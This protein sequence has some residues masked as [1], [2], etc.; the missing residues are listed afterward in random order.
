MELETLEIFIE[1]NTEKIQAQ[2]EPLMPYFD[3]VFGNIERI[4]GQSV[5]RTEKKM[6]VG[7]G[8]NN[9][10][11]QFE[12]MQ[13]MYEK[14]LEMME[15]ITSSSTANIEK[16]LTKG[17]Q[18]SRKTVGKEVDALVKDINN[19]MG[20]AKAE[21]EKLA[22]LQ[23]QR[24]DASS[25]GDTKNVV[26]YDG[27][28]ARAQEM[29]DKYQGS[30][31][32]MANTIKKEFK[33]LPGLMDSMSDEMQK[34]ESVIESQKA[35]V[36]ELT[37]LYETQ[38]KKVSKLSQG[39]L[40]NLYQKYG[41]TFDPNYQKEVKQA[42]F[43]FEDTK[44]SKKTNAEITKYNKEIQ[45]LI[46][47]NDALQQSYSQAEDRTKQLRSAVKGLN[48][49]L[50]KSSMVTGNAAMGMKKVGKGADDSKGLFSKFGGVFNRTS[51]NIAHGSRRMTTGISGFGHRLSQM[52]KQAFI[53][54][55][56]YK[57]LNM[58]TKGLGSALMA[59]DE[60]SS[61]L[62]QIKV[63]LLTAFY[64]IYTF[65][66]PAINSL[67]RA[68]TVATGQIAH[69]TASLFGTTYTA[70]KQGAQGLYQNIQAMNDSGNSADKNREKV[71]KL[72]RS[73]MGFDE[74]N[75]I[76]LDDKDDDKLD[77]KNQGVNFNTPIPAMPDWIGKANSILRDFF[78]PF[79]D[80]WA[81]H[82]QTVIKAWK[83]ALGE[84]VGLAQSIGK[85]FMDVWTNGTGEQ[86]ISNI[87]ILVANL[88]GLVGDV[89]KAFKNAWD[90]NE[91]GTKLIQSLFDMWNAFLGLT[92]EIVKSFR[93][94]WNENKLGES[95]LGNILEIF[96]NLIGAV[97]ELGKG[98][99]NA[100]KENETG[101][102]ILK[103]ILGFFDDILG[104]LNDASKHTKEWA[105][106][107]DFTPLLKSIDKL[108]KPI[109]E[110][111]KDVFEVLGWAYDNILLPLAKLII[112]DVL[113]V[114]FNLLGNALGIVAKVL[115]D[116]KPLFMWL[117]DKLIKPLVDFTLGAVSDWLTFL[118]KFGQA[119]E[120]LLT[121]DIGSFG[122]IVE[123][124][125]Q[126]GKDIWDGLKE[127]L[128]SFGS[129]I[130]T[131]IR[132]S[133]FDP[134]VNWFKDLFGIHSP[135]TIFFEFGTFLMQGLINGIKSLLSGPVDL[136]KKLWDD[137]SGAVVTKGSVIWDSSKKVWDDV[138]TKVKTKATEAWT[139]TKD[140]WENIKKN[141]GDNFETVRKWTS[142]KWDN[143]KDKITNSSSNARTNASNSW[144]NLKE[145]VDGYNNNIRNNT[146]NAFNAVVKASSDLGGRIGSGMSKGWNA[147][148]NGAKSVA[149][150]LK[151]FPMKA[152][153]SIKDGVGWVLGKLG[154]KNTM[155]G[156][157]AGTKAYA[158]GTGYHPGGMALV[159]DGYG[160]NFRE[161]Y[162]LPN[163]QT[164]LFPNQ[165]NLMV[166]L[167]AGS[168]VLSGPRTASMYGNT[169]A[170]AGGIGKW[171]NEKWENF[172]EWTGDVW[173]YMSHP[174]KLV[175]VGISKFANLRGALEPSLSIA[176]G[177]IGTS[178]DAATSFV[179]STMES[180]FDSGGDADTSTSG[181]MGVMS[182]LANIARDVIS[183][184][185]GMR[186]T[187]GYRHGDPYS[188]GKRQAI[189]IAYPSNMNGSSEYFKSANYA[190]EKFRDKVAYVITQ[191][192]VRDR[193]GMSGTGSSGQW[194]G[195]PDNDHYDHLH[196]NGSIAQGQGGG[197][198]AGSGV[199]RWR[200]TV[201][202]ALY[203]TGQYSTAN[204]DRTLY[205]M[206]TES[207]G[208][209]NAINLWDSNAMAGIPSKGLMQVIDPTFNA[210]AKSP[211]NK[212]I[213]DP[214]SNIMASVRYSIARYGSLAN[215][216]R[217]VGY[218][219]GT[220]YLP[221]DQLA[222]I[223]KGEM[224]VP[225]DFNPY[226][227]M[228]DYQT[229]QMPELFRENSKPVNYTYTP[230]P[231][232]IGGGMSGATEGI[233]NAVMM[234]LS[235]R[236]STPQQGGDIHVTVEVD[237]KEMTKV[238]I[239]EHN[240]E[241]RN[242]GKSPLLI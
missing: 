220:P 18:Q 13:K 126:F 39:Q 242:Q 201:A 59:N 36:R 153:N 30:A 25:K 22:F 58:V 76:G 140:K 43:K 44:S 223:H 5:N 152:I 167:P 37:A 112:E 38:A 236:D 102:S 9:I 186:V 71:K 84:I 179:K 188:H 119:L 159:N 174:S 73:L 41:N 138:S 182:Y 63:N 137:M 218:A 184:Y 177:S 16:G 189:D 109:K 79:Q 21:Q 180:L 57:G 198:K 28:I 239:D 123:R 65:I 3:K 96:T 53:F 163:G 7:D 165:R 158:Q 240:K 194:R 31:I 49:E 211:Y 232:D 160:S 204:I 91:R 136:V 77:D 226:N 45:K 149:N 83:Y 210:Y 192:R 95:I 27:Q 233:V 148:T 157:F 120:D 48:T 69:F 113:P 206:Q 238:V 212:N 10:N 221:E 74:I 86:F 93:D 209:P 50:G 85:S 12:Q 19:K 196:I 107:L 173:D 147:I 101:T 146:N 121:I 62:N 46:S 6:D 75:R 190:F 161:A 187:S 222:M 128:S 89:A 78:K 99:K 166:D 17:F 116:V 129:N 208:N 122:D 33:T 11:K 156:D 68:L 87:L 105:K 47:K 90:E 40:S 213:W 94:A 215:A 155:G 97:G 214:L 20:R 234:A 118:G 151:G 111:S 115:R 144:S 237:G 168:S 110:I 162:Q 141:T 154:A 70:A 139:N 104:V 134:I 227:N 132:E 82:G 42:G 103:T 169:P 229:L 127:G 117:L 145:R 131:F 100:W 185:P 29:M 60:F 205:Q 171:F 203:R 4:T 235:M 202:E 199:Q 193:S 98:L 228:A 66:L 54:S 191:G 24:Q 170:Y 52:I 176:Q 231:K 175:E 124:F 32:A 55:V 35:K 88:L 108:L 67:M 217:G 64:P 133:M 200:S 8:V 72:Q 15:K 56:I 14:N 142:D 1:A 81:K 51:N 130:G 143:I 92:N 225:A 178:M 80:S 219:Q 2:L 26:K 34:N 135:S 23:A 195:W 207:G 114:F 224:I 197:P 181:T 164:G 61:S 125:K 106:E 241:V 150:A 172:K 216:Y 230:E 183:K